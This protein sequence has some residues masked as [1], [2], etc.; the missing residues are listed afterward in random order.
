MKDFEYNWATAEIVKLYL[1]NSRAQEA[2]KAR[3]TSEVSAG[4][5]DTSAANPEVINNVGMSRPTG[6]SDSDSSSDED[7]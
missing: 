2:R 3:A 4:T 5:Q 7:Q 1:R 6:D